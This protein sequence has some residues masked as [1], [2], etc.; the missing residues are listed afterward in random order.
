MDAPIRLTAAAALLWL[1]P[2]AAAEWKTL[3]VDDFRLSL[4]GDATPKEGTTEGPAGRVRTQEWAVEADGVGFRLTIAYYAPETLAKPAKVLEAARDALVA[5]A[6]STLDRDFAIQIDSGQP[7]KKWP[8]R[9]FASH[10]E[11]GVQLNTRI[12]LVDDRLFVLSVVRPAD[13]VGDGTDLARFLDS[14]KLKKKK[15]RKD[16]GW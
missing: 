12:F 2:A 5:G 1:L 7:R 3:V 9:E 14:F 15:E 4:P 11:A 6:S 13:Q 10:T 16:A 8:G